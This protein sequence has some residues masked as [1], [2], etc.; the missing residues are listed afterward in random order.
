MNEKSFRNIGLF[1]QCNFDRFFIVEG[2]LGGDIGVILV[3]I[4]GEIGA[5]HRII[6]GNSEGILGQF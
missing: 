1:I 4:F 3:G 6:W 5:V 2:Q